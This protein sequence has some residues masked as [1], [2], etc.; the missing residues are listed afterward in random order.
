MMTHVFTTIAKLIDED[1][2]AYISRTLLENPLDDDTRE[3]VRG[4]IKEAMSPKRVR[5]V[6]DCLFVIV[7]AIKKQERKKQQKQGNM[8][9][10]TPTI[11]TTPTNTTRPKTK[12][13]HTP[14]TDRQELP[15]ILN[16]NTNTKKK[17]KK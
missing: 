3:S 16:N 4:I 14:P 9:N 11:E 6:C 15:V 2:E 5:I 12:K 1:T 7:D 8:T 10:A 17:K 13:T